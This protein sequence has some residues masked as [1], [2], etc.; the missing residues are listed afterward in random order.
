M[1]QI[2]R[3]SESLI[4]PLHKQ[5]MAEVCHKC[6][7]WV[8]L[9]GTNPNSG[10]TLDKWDCSLSWLPLLLVE[11]SKEARASTKATESFRNLV[12]TMNGVEEIKRLNH[13]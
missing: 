12:A 7:L 11:T 1:Q 5:V 10:E 3:G 2:P 8:Q 13:G 6:P 4:C 9:K